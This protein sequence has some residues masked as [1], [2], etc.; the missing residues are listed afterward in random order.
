MKSL[1]KILYC[2]MF[3]LVSCYPIYET[4]VDYTPPATEQGKKCIIECGFIKNNCYRQCQKQVNECEFK[5]KLYNIPSSVINIVKDTNNSNKSADNNKNNNN[6]SNSTITITKTI[7]KEDKKSICNIN[8]CNR[9]CRNDYNLCY[10]DCG[11][12]VTFN[13]VCTYFCDKK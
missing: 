8:N 9:L 4:Q 10:T 5:E 12:K 11:G 3:S 7:S 13:E 6:N 1:A 2:I